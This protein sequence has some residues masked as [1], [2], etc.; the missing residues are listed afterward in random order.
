MEKTKKFRSYISSTGSFI[1]LPEA[2]EGADENVIYAPKIEIRTQK[3]DDSKHP[4]GFEHVMYPHNLLIDFEALNAKALDI[5]KLIKDCELIKETAEKHPEELK[6]ILGSFA[7]DA[8]HE[9][10]LK[11]DE[12]VKKLGLS[13]EVV[14]KKG[15]G[16]LWLLVIAAALA[17]SS[18]KGCAHTTGRTRQN[19]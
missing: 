11:A 8:P 18:C 15:G 3:F 2:F 16:L 17:M 9:E 1:S 7:Q 12:L 19:P 6:F 14:T 13:E 4:L 5:N 10:M